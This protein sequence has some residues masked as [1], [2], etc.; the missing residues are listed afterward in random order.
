VDPQWRIADSEY[1]Q[2]PYK[3]M[4]RIPF[5]W[6]PGNCG[7]GWVEVGCWCCRVQIVKENSGF[8]KAL[9]R[10]VSRHT[11]SRIVSRRVTH[12]LEEDG[13]V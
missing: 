12:A 10:L 7:G 11:I 8:E 9:E 6:G 5:Q 13:W 3:G 1:L 4:Q 2:I